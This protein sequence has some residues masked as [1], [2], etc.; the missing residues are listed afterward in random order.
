MPGGGK[1]LIQTSQ[2]NGWVVLSVSDTGCGMSPEFLQH[3]LFR[4]FSTTKKSGIGIGVFHCKMI[5]EAHGGKIE[6]DSELGKGSVFRVLLPITR[7]EHK[8]P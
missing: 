1:I 7:K 3:S 8:G 4:P 5:V 2:R 6:V